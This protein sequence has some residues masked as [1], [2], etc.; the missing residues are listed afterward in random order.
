MTHKVRF[1]VRHEGSAL[2][3]Q[4]AAQTISAQ[5]M[6]EY[7]CCFDGFEAIKQALIDAGLPTEIAYAGE[8]ATVYEVTGQQLR[9]IGFAIEDSA[10]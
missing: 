5:S 10:L 2:V 1:S 7:V 4:P 6:A 9:D 8:N 3:F